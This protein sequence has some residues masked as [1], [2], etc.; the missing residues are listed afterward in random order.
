MHSAVGKFYGVGFLRPR[1]VVLPTADQKN[2]ALN[3]DISY[4]HNLRL[5]IFSAI[6]GLL[7]VINFPIVESLHEPTPCLLVTCV[8]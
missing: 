4:E 2:I 1:A 5:T 6:F 3:Y 8:Q 7:V